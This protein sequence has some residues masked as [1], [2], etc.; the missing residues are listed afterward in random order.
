VTTIT[1]I[2]GAQAAVE[3]M[4]YMDELGVISIQEMHALL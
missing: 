3:G 2:F 1:T 4:Q